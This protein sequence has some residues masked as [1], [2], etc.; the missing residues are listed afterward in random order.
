LKYRIKPETI[1]LSPSEAK[2][3]GT[4]QIEQETKG[5]QLKEWKGN[6]QWTLVKE[7]GT[8]KVRVIQYQHSQKP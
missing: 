5:G 4:Y 1:D 8:L 3:R 7:Q 6:I 2:V